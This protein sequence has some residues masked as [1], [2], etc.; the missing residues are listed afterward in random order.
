MLLVKSIDAT[1]VSAAVE[2]LPFAANPPPCYFG[3]A[4]DIMRYST[5]VKDLSRDRD[6]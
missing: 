5:T 6:A 3:V 2:V 1:P 4:S